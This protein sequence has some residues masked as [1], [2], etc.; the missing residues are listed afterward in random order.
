M[1]ATI[2]FIVTPADDEEEFENTG[3]EDRKRNGREWD[4]F[5]VKSGRLLETFFMKATKSDLTVIAC[6]DRKREGR[7]LKTRLLV[8]EVV[9]EVIPDLEELVEK[10]ADATA[11]A[12][13]KHGGGKAD[14]ARISAA[15]KSEAWPDTDDAAEEAAAFAY[16]LLWFTRAAK[17]AKMG[18]CWEYRGDVK[19]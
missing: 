7:P 8:R 13:Q 15:L 17:K 18:L 5:P 19:V 10:N 6:P 2:T 4:E 12:L 11:R 3:V 16:Q 14:L 1:S 9:P